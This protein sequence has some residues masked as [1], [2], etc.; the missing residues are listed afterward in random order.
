MRLLRAMRPFSGAVLNSH[1]ILAAL[2]ACANRPGTRKKASSKRIALRAS[3]SPRAQPRGLLRFVFRQWLTVT[4]G[5][6]SLRC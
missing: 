2:F 5:D 1:Y 4:R 6:F 3:V